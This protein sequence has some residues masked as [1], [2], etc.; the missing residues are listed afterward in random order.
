MALRLHGHPGVVHTRGRAPDKSPDVVMTLPDTRVSA[1]PAPELTQGDAAGA[2]AGAGEPGAGEIVGHAD[3]RLLA[4]GNWTELVRLQ[5]KGPGC[6][7]YRPRY[8]VLLQEHVHR[9][10][11]K[12]EDLGHETWKDRPPVAGKQIY[13]HGKIGRELW[14]VGNFLT[15]IDPT[16]VRARHHVCCACVHAAHAA[17]LHGAQGA[18]GGAD[19]PRCDTLLR[20]HL[21]G[22]GL[23][24]PD[25]RVVGLPAASAVMHC[26]RRGARPC[27]RVHALRS[28]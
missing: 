18:A 23:A 21:C 8:I 9:C 20:V 5:R 22:G 24:A 19:S 3:M 12:V 25:A 27:V 7:S 11:R 10:H 13:K 6:A 17:V 15:K 14:E 1:S 28:T 2:V 26:A 16:Y 4:L